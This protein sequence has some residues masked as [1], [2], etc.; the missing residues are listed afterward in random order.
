MFLE[1]PT[2]NHSY[3]LCRACRVCRTLAGCFRFPLQSPG[4]LFPKFSLLE[5]IQI[6]IGVLNRTYRFHSDRQIPIGMRNRT[7]VMKRIQVAI[8]VS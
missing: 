8:Q 7:A 3:S 5:K 6:P 1:G 4:G 2:A